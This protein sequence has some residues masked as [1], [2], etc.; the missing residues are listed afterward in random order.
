MMNVF[1]LY[2]KHV[3]FQKK[4]KKKEKT[5]KRSRRAK[6]ILRKKSKARSITISNFKLYCKATV[7]KPAWDC[8][9]DRHMDQRN[10]KRM[11]KQTHV[12]TAS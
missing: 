3:L 7:P 6:A 8:Y 4:K 12:T 1:I 11:S 5:Y 2:C 9:K 10:R